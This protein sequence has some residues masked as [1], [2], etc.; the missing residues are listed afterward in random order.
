ME[1][2]DQPNKTKKVFKIIAIILLI[3]LVLGSSATAYY[4]FDKAKDA[5]KEMDTAKEA[6]ES[7]KTELERIEKLILEKKGEVAKTA[8]VGETSDCKSA[9]TD[10]EEET[11]TDWDTYTSTIYDYSI[12]HPSDW[13]VIDENANSVTLTLAGDEEDSASMQIRTGTAT[14]IGFAGYT[15]NTEGTTLVSCFDALVKNYSVDANGR[16][17]V[18]NTINSGKNFLFMFSYEYAGASA[19]ATMVELNDLMIKTVD[20]S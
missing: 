16:M 6:A 8:D 12:K 3:I 14:E 15:L 10:S 13:T 1:N 5:K 4:Y 20:F 9:L 18:T 2:F 17:I 19:D 7:V 11:I